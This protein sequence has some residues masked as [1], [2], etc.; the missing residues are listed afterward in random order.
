MSFDQEGRYESEDILQ[1]CL[2][3]SSRTPETERALESDP[4]LRESFEGFESSVAGLRSALSREEAATN[5]AGLVDQILR[6]TTREDLTWRGDLRL[7]GEYLG[8]HVKSSWVVKLVA[9]SLVAHLT[10]LPILGFMLLTKSPESGFNLRL[11]EPIDLP[12][13]EVQP[14]P[15]R[16]LDE[17]ALV[18][19]EELEVLLE[20]QRR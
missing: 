2:D 10:A 1:W 6:A 20:D 13:E 8:R 12:F 5:D 3:P 9:A 19:P 16:E 18:S 11:E 17:D 14:E 7:V 4:L 15:D